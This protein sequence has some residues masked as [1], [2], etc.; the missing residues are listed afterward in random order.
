[1]RETRGNRQKAASLSVQS[2]SDYDD[3]DD[4]EY[5]DRGF[6][7]HLN[8]GFAQQSM[9]VVQF[10][11]TTERGQ[12]CMSGEIQLHSGASPHSEC[13]VKYF[14]MFQRPLRLADTAA[15]VQPNW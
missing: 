4:A 3:D 1:M 8:R 11:P 6:P 9:R 13:F 2:F 12:L 14:Y 10:P 5:L 7:Q 15:I